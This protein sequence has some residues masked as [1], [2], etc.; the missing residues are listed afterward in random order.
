MIPGLNIHRVKK[1]HV[2]SERGGDTRWLYL[3]FAGEGEQVHVNLFPKDQTVEGVEALA[4]D[5]IPSEVKEAIINMIDSTEQLNADEG[6][7][8]AA[9]MIQQDALQSLKRMLKLDLPSK[10]GA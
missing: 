8:L 7:C 4:R 5:L 6:D 10:T 3:R 1:V 9:S 2:T